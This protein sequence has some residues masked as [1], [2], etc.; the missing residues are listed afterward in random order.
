MWETPS[1]GPDPRSGSHGDKM[2]L[3]I[4]PEWPVGDKSGIRNDTSPALRWLL[5]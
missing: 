2:R 4:P 3:L 5:D 1:P